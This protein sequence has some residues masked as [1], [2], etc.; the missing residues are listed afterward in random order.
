MFRNYPINPKRG[1]EIFDPFTTVSELIWLAL[2]T[3]VCERT[4]PNK[5]YISCELTKDKQQF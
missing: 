1:E 5:K 4:D 3:P 2:T